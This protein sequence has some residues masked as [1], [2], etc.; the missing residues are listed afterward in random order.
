LVDSIEYGKNITLINNLSN[1]MPVLKESDLFVLSSF[2]EG[3]PM[4]LMEADTLCVPMISTDIESTRA[5]G[6]Y[7]GVI[8][9]NSQEGILQGMH[10]FVSGNVK[11]KNSD[12]KMY[13][14][15]AVDEFKRLIDE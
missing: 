15:I 13:N 14:E 4:V 7:A 5:M 8:V 1:P 12:F 3:W 6:D 11:C 9:E 2:H 10:D